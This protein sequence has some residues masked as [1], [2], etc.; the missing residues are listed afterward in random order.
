M[1]KP[2]IRLLAVL[3]LS[4]ACTSG[5]T[6]APEPEHREM[7]G[8]PVRIVSLF[9]SWT[10][11]LFALGVGDRVVGRS[12][13]CDHPPEVRGLP[14][15]GDGFSLNLEA[16]L[17]LKPDLVLLYDRA[18]CSR[19]Q[20]LGIQA[21]SVQGE[22]L[23]EIY[24]AYETIAEA[25]GVSGKGRVLSARVRREIEEQGQR[26]AGAVRKRVLWCVD[27]RSG[28]VVGSGNFVHELLLVVG[29]V[30]VASDAA[31]SYPVYSLEA[32]IRK[33]PEVILDSTSPG[34]FG[35]NGT[36]KTFIQGLRVTTA[37]RKG[38]ILNVSHNLVTRSGPRLGR[39]AELLGELIHPEWAGSGK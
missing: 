4:L 26:F 9:P 21:L 31:R 1:R 29:G 2:V 6:P 10:E 22:T 3:V 20:R 38:R 15:V 8:S 5:C 12:R 19:I 14:A 27:G 24:A 7:D 17:S 30:N 11:V 23:E 13:H 16:L 25:V 36:L 35:E 33:D 28:H 37:G 32:A 18:L 34:G 39:A